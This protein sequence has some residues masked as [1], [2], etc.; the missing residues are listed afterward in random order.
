MLDTIANCHN[1]MIWGSGNPRQILEPQRESLKCNVFCAVC[2][3]QVYGPLF[4]M[5]SSITGSVYLDMLT[6]FLIPQLDVDNVIFQQDGAPPH[7]HRVVTSFLSE[8]FP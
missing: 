7:Y 4:F 8:T 6:E 3:R 1:V 5:E 2:Q